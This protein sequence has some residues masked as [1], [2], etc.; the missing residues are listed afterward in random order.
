MLMAAPTQTISAS[1]RE[2]IFTAAPSAIYA[3]T[4]PGERRFRPRRCLP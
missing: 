1:G 2:L 4:G 3:D